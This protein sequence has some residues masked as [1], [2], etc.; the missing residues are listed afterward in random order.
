ML[1]VLLGCFRLL[2]SDSDGVQIAQIDLIA[3]EIVNFGIMLQSLHLRFVGDLACA[4]LLIYRCCFL[5]LRLKIFLQRFGRILGCLIFK[6]LLG[7]LLLANM[8]LICLNF[9]QIK[10]WYQIT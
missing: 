10:R 7:G 4:T 5:I 6:L 3:N 2:F 1:L 9:C 8:L